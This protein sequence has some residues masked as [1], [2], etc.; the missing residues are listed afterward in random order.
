MEKVQGMIIMMKLES[1][2]K[3]DM[4]EMGDTERAVEPMICGVTVWLETG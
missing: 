4:K 3:E 1:V 2:G